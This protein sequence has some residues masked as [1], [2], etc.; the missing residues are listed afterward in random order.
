[1]LQKRQTISK[2]HSETLKMFSPIADAFHSSTYLR[3]IDFPI[4]VNIF[5]FLFGVV[6]EERF[7]LL[8]G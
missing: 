3:L 7:M 2:L 8:L 6:V 5:T 1:M 4:V